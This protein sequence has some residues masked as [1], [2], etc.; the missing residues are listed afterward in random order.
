M[1]PTAFADEIVAKFTQPG[2][3]V[4]DPFAGRGTSVFSA[5]AAGRRALGVEINPVGWVYASAKLR[6]ADQR[7]VAQRIERLGSVAASF[8]VEVDRLPVFFHH[9]F[10]PQVR[11]FLLAARQ[12]LD[13][14]GRMVDRTVMA[15]LL[16]YLHGKRGASL[17]NQMRQTKAL[18]PDYAVRWWSSRDMHP[19]ELDPVPFMLDR[20]TW[21]YAYGRPRGL[22]GTVYLGD[23]TEKLSKVAGILNKQ[24]AKVKLLFTSPPYYKVTNYHYDQWLRLWLLGGRPDARRTGGQHRAKFENRE[25]Y[26]TLLQR[27]FSDVRRMLANDAVIYVRTDRR[28]ITFQCTLTVLQ[29][30]FAGWS[31]QAIDQPFRGQTQTHLFGGRSSAGGEIDLLLTR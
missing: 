18:S 14:R 28:P 22:Q 16:V 7:L 2:D 17:S 31:V 8:A 4:L 19:P 29:E 5:A 26:R 6:P 27:V 11:Q 30:V 3:V 20:L 15:L 9:C 1:F 10:C 23:S 25:N 24:G 21:R 12:Y 13:W